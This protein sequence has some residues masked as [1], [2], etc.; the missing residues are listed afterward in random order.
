MQD[1]LLHALLRQHLRAGQL[2]HNGVL[3]SSPSLS[4]SLL[5]TGL[6]HD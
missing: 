2:L 3:P 6:L 1:S 4:E 5:R